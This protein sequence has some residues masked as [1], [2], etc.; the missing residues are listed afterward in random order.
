MDVALCIDLFE[1][2][3][4]AW[5]ATVQAEYVHIQFLTKTYLIQHASRSRKIG[6][7]PTLD[8]CRYINRQ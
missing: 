3:F 6:V 4:T 2:T 7:W 8:H 1:D 5:V